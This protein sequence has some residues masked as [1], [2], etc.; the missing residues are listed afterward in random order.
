MKTWL[1]WALIITQVGG[2]F[3]GIA[4][5]G[6]YLYNSEHMPPP[7]IVVS[8]IFIAL[9]TFVTVAG[10]LYALN[11]Q[12]TGPLRVAL[13]LQIPWISSMIITWKFVAGFSF[14]LTL[15]DGR[16]NVVYW[17]GSFWQ[18][19]IFEEQPAGIGINL[20]AVLMLYF[21]KRVRDFQP[22]VQPALAE[23]VNSI[24]QSHLMNTSL[25]GREIHLQSLPEGKLSIQVGSDQ[26]SS[27]DEL[28]EEEIRLAIRS[29][30]ADWENRGRNHHH[31]RAMT[32]WWWNL[33][34]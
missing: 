5:T 10:V 32:R 17:L 33:L 3:T 23:Q 19:N 29:T 6:D 30:I 11:E 24:L 7:I 21:L 25:A 18:F 12:R 22:N 31:W 16:L 26:Y 13:W 34:T 2:G 9:Y 27:V 1:R 8:T 28:P 15:F 14:A 20:F 4:I